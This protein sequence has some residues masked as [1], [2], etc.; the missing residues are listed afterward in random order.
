MISDKFE[1]VQKAVHGI[2]GEYFTNLSPQFAEKSFDL[3]EMIIK[4]KN[5]EAREAQKAQEMGGGKKKRSKHWKLSVGRYIQAAG[6]KRF[7][8]KYPL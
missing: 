1:K 2:I 6:I 7:M 3:V 5:F 8:Q 4:Q